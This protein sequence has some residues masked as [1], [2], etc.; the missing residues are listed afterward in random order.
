MKS[1]DVPME[2]PEDPEDDVPLDLDGNG[3]DD[4]GLLTMSDYVQENVAL[5][6]EQQEEKESDHGEVAEE[7]EEWPKAEMAMVV[8]KYKVPIKIVSL[9]D[10]TGSFVE[11]KM[12]EFSQ[13]Q[14]ANS[15][16]NTVAQWLWPLLGFSPKEAHL[17]KDPWRLPL[18]QELLEKV[19]ATRRKRLRGGGHTDANGSVLPQLMTVNIRGTRIIVENNIKKMSVNLGD[20]LATMNWFLKT[21]WEERHKCHPPMQDGPGWRPVFRQVDMDDNVKR[22]VKEH[23]KNLTD[24]ENCK[25]AHFF[26]HTS[27]F[28]ACRKGSAPKWFGVRRFKTILKNDDHAAVDDLLTLV[29][30]S[31][32]KHLEED[33]GGPPEQ[34]SMDSANADMIFAA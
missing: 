21:L 11:H 12:V 3:D 28:R 1:E 23:L 7:K 20:D 32:V 16:S 15:E 14:I 34:P 6:W 13:R 27:R 25:Y 10:S 26:P 5:A 8:G 2:L 19:H 29:T 30:V 22:I 9:P 24:H 33:P 31:I 17:G 18:M 4:D